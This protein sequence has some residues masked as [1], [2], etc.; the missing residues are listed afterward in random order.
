MNGTRSTRLR[1]PFKKSRPTFVDVCDRYVYMG[2]MD[3]ATCRDVAERVDLSLSDVLYLP[4]GHEIVFE[5][6]RR[7]TMTE[8]WHITEGP[9]WQALYQ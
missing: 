1:I 6:D 4:L 8:R 7:P 5:R 2:G 9:D 3:L